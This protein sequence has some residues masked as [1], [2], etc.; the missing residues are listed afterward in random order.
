MAKG[1]GAGA[2][3]TP[4]VEEEPGVATCQAVTKKGAG[5][6]RTP[7]AGEVFCPR[8][9]A[10]G[11][12]AREAALT[13]E[14]KDSLG[15]E[16]EAAASEAGETGKKPNGEDDGEDLLREQDLS[17]KETRALYRDLWS[18]VKGVLARMR[19]VLRM[20]LTGEA[21]ALFE[22]FKARLAAM[23]PLPRIRI[24]TALRDLVDSDLLDPDFWEG[25]WYV[26]RSSAEAKVDQISRHWK[27]DYEVDE[28]GMDEEF[29]DTL[30]PIANFFYKYWWR[31]T[32]H[33]VE[34][35]PGSGRTL[36]AVNHSGVL[37]FDAAMVM[38]AVWNEHPEPRPVR[39]LYLRWFAS[40]PFLAPLLSR[41][42]Q[43]VANPDNARALLERDQLV[44]VFPEGIKGVGKLY[45][46][47]YKLA[48][49]GRGGFIRTAMQTLAPIVP[50]AVVGA[51]EIY[52]TLR[53]WDWLG[54][55][56]GMPYFPITPT[57]PWLGLL[58]VVPLPSKWSIDFCKPVKF[59]ENAKTMTEDYLVLSLLTE[60]IRKEIQTT[61]WRRL[62]R[63]RSIWY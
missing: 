5:C 32:A 35:V 7:R 46:D 49:F 11:A 10:E 6:R 45:K 27:G 25:L 39:T 3:Q 4:R 43:V 18:K 56:L 47:R 9:L 1:N 17:A 30:R 21:T 8:H 29:L 24:K 61:L 50:V 20:D 42:G 54:K 26:L 15:A 33:T 22:G 28:F 37:P 31:C 58:G 19:G 59:K 60:M 14:T 12:E 16:A 40:I 38:M 2:V 52:P 13:E 62:K 48:R 41:A 63:R 57:F 44:S 23:N 53:R 55:P 36:L 51:E 34:N